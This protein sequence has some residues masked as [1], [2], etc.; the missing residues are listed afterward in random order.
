M[1]E[2]IRVSADDLII[3]FNVITAFCLL[4][5]CSLT[6]SPKDASLYPM[7]LTYFSSSPDTLEKSTSEL[8]S[9]L[10]HIDAQDLLPP[11]QVIKALSH[12]DVASLSLIKNYMGR[13]IEKERKEMERV[14]I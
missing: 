1:R 13:K 5:L 8:L 6:Y 4:T 11:L 12:N 14:C 7:V 9:V 3:G 2:K 10:D